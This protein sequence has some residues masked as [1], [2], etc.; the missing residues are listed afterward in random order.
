[1]SICSYR[2]EDPSN[3]EVRTKVFEEKEGG[4]DGQ[5][6]VHVIYKRSLAGIYGQV[7]AVDFLLGLLTEV[8]PG[9]SFSDISQGFFFLDP[10]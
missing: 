10:L 7:H 9:I 6:L 8:L 3:E 2:R 1:M 5:I 4:W